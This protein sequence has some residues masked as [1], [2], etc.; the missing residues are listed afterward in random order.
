MSDPSDP[1]A[2]TSAVPDRVTR[3]PAVWVA[4]AAV[5]A[6]LSVLAAVAV[7][8]GPRIG[9]VT[10]A[11]AGADSG[12]P[13]TRPG[14]GLP[15]EVLDPAV[16]KAAIESLL[17]DRAAAI[18]SDDA[19]RW[20]ELALPS[21]RVP[22]FSD[23]AAL[24][25]TTWRYTVEATTSG[26][27]PSEV[28]AQV[29]VAYRFDVDE[30]DALLRERL[31]LRHTDDGWRVATE[32]TDGTRAQPWDLGTVRVARGARSLVIG[33]DVAPQTIQRYAEIADAVA[34]D[35]TDVWGPG[36]TR[37]PV[38]VVPRTTALLGRGLAR[39][40]SALEQIA[41]VTTAEDGERDRSGARGADRVWTNTPVMAS[42]SA[43][44]R[45]IVL[46]HEVLHVAT[47]AAA[48]GATPLWL[49]EG[50]AEYVGY[51]GSGVP[52]RTATGDVLRAVREGRAPGSLPTVRDFS[53][54]E[55]AQAYE[56]A[57]VACVVVAEEAGARRAGRA[58]PAYGARL[59]ERGG[60]RR[61][62]AAGRC[63]GTA[64]TSSSRAGGPG[65]AR[66]RGE[67]RDRRGLADGARRRARPGRPD[68]AL[69]A[70]GAGSDRVGRRHRRRLH[71]GR[72]AS[73][74]PTSVAACARSG[75]PRWRWASWCRPCSCSRAVPRRSPVRPPARGGCRSSPRSRSC[76]WSRVRRR[77]RSPSSYA[78]AR[79]T[80]GWRR[81][82]GPCGGATWSW[83]RCC[84]GGSPRWPSWAGSV[85]RGCGRRRGGSWWRAWPR[86]SWCCSRSSSPC[87]S[88]RSS[89]GSPR[90]RTRRCARGCSTSPSA[91]AWWCATCS[92]RMRHVVRAPSTPTSPAW[93]PRAASSCTT[94]WSTAVAT[95][96]R[97]PSSRTS[98]ATSWRTTCAPGR[99]W[100]PRGAVVAVAAA[101]VALSWSWLL[102]LA[103][104]TG[105]SDPAVAAL[106]LALG[107]WAGLLGAPRAERRVA[108]DRAPGR[109]AL[110]RP[111][112]R[113]RHRGGHAPLA[114]G[115]E[116]RAAAAAT[117]AAPVVRHAPH[118]AGAHRGCSRAGHGP[119]ARRCRGRS[120]AR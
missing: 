53:G 79:S 57:H 98:S 45:E 107:G 10:Q 18:T 119:P 61:R 87:W 84:R 106:L 48:T 73:A 1:A 32:S 116:P 21:A 39:A 59:G 38:V 12:T 95:T 11:P 36:W 44:G 37:S 70:A 67:R 114:G 109:P 82:R 50:F 24:P 4:A 93:D 31:T 90:C 34:A 78:A 5:V 56:S 19:A 35:V 117:A 46:R 101:A 33:I 77:C 29:S 88:S 30:Q 65:C 42:L 9:A 63:S 40:P 26:A 100:A 118:V 15:D 60:Q 72:A 103:S 112:P 58:L 89:R 113:R 28:S 55:L 86:R 27:D 71:A 91:T 43:L 2:P 47:G 97:T 7:P 66:W 81:A 41:A 83:R 69:G 20:R 62:R 16:R 23:L 64:P 8:G 68:G 52:L 13:L 17:A 14:P 94:P 54:D 120:R 22:D 76:C 115:H 96:R 85:L 75:W 99:C 92:S 104:V 102:D 105:P 111:R 25:I 6:G 51:R 74:R 3:R 108:P 80:W 49:E 110:P